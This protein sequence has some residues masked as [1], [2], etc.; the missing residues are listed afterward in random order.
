MTHYLINHQPSDGRSS[1]RLAIG[2]DY[3]KWQSIQYIRAHATDLAA[4]IAADLVADLLANLTA[5]LDI[6]L[7]AD[8]SADLTA[9]I[10]VELAADLHRQR[11]FSIAHIMS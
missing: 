6:D 10:V 4:D 7:L 5:H 9:N 3:L 11:P 1:D 2:A 8:F